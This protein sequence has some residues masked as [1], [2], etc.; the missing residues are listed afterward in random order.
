MNF[1]K[2]PQQMLA[3]LQARLPGADGKPDA[4]KIKAFTD[5][6]PETTNQGKYL[7]SRP[8]PAS[9]VGSATG[10]ST[11]TPSPMRKGRRRS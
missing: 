11:P 8:V 2:S 1:V 4:E 6:N 3:F 5:A 10:R 9:W 7:A